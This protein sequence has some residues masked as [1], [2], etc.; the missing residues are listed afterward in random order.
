MLTKQTSTNIDKSIAKFSLALAN[1]EYRDKNYK[2]NEDQ[3]SKYDKLIKEILELKSNIKKNNNSYFKGKG[4]REKIDRYE[5]NL[6]KKS[7]ELFIIIH[8][9]F[10]CV[11]KDKRDDIYKALSGDPDNDR[12][13]SK[14]INTARDGIFYGA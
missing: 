1:R 9:C 13:L 5:K 11:I 6:E 7:E 12:Y 14:I 10:N 8:T 2:E 3:Q 4:L